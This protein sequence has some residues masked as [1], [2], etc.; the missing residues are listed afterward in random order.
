MATCTVKAAMKWKDSP[1]EPLVAKSSGTIISGLEKH[2]A[3]F[4]RRT[5]QCTVLNGNKV[6]WTAKISFES[7]VAVCCG[8]FGVLYCLNNTTVCLRSQVSLSFVCRTKSPVSSIV[9]SEAFKIFAVATLN[10]DIT[11]YSLRTGAQVMTSR[12]HNE[13]LA[14]LITPMFGFIVVITKLHI[15]LLSVDGD[16]LKSVPHAFDVRKAFVVSSAHDL[17]YVA[18]I[19]SEN[20]LVF[21]EA[22]YPDHSVTVSEDLREPVMCVSYVPIIGAFVTVSKNGLVRTVGGILP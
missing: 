12:V 20:K 9:A 17:D 18:L 19:T 16:F 22:L 11:V 8:V 2:V 13:I 4:D 5:L 1:K 3:V 10:G 15:T 7:S 21:F 6:E 14:M